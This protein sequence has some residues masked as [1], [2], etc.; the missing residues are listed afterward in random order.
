M[1]FYYLKIATRALLK[2]KAYTITMLL[3]LSIG[4]ASCILILLFVADELSFDQHHERKERIYRL[5][6]AVQGSDFEG[7]AK[8]NGPWGPAAQQEIPEIEAMTRFVICGELLFDNGNQKF[9]EPNGFY[10]DSSVFDI[11]SYDF[12]QGDPSTSLVGPKKIVITETFAKRYFGNEDAWGK[13]LRIDSDEDYIVTGILEDIPTTSHFTFDYLLSMPSLQN[14]LKHSWTEWNQFYTYFLLRQHTVTDDVENKIMVMLQKN[15][16]PELASNY[17][18]FLQALTDI[19]LRSHLHREMNANSD[20]L[21]IYIFSS[22]ALLILAISSVNFINTTTARATRRAKEIG[23]RKVNGAARRQLVIQF[24]TEVFV[25]C[26]A[27]LLIAQLLAVA[28]LP[29]LND[30]TA[31]NIDIGNLTQPIFV[32]GSVGITILTALLAGSYPA[33]YQSSLKPMQ[34]LKGRWSPSGKVS[35]QKVLVAFQFALSSILVIASVIIFRQLQFI[36]SKPLGFDP[37]QII[38]IPIQS[39]KLRDSYETVKHELLK[40]PGVLSVS[41]SGNIPGGSDWGI[42]TLPEGF[43]GDNSPS[44]RVM[45]VDQDFLKTYGMTVAYGRNFSKVVVTDTTAYLINEEAVKQLN[46]QDPLLK[47]F[48]MPAV[49]RPS[50][51]VVGV[52]KDFHFRSIHEEIGPLLFFIP[53]SKWYSIYSIKIDVRQSEETLKFVKREWE[54]FDPEHPFTFTFFDDQYTK[55][56]E[57]ERRLGTIVGYF[58]IIGIFLACMGLYSLASYTTEQRKKEIG[59]R[60]VIGASRI[61]VVA[62]LSKQYLVVLL[63]GFGVAL[64]IAWH[65]LNQWLNSFAYHVNFNLLLVITCGMMLMLI[66]LLTVGYRGLKAA[67]ANPV[68]SLKNE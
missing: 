5:A 9:Y 17:T 19:H 29:V 10:A 16:A 28:A 7:I 21:Y 35:L 6:T 44:I 30:L 57:Q 32:F 45:A 66:A 31:K 68:D 52:V 13:T 61:Q 18:P 62:L 12:I 38:T 63:V 8:V 40:H 24:L 11:F 25:I 27:S 47:T 51:N 26:F 2:Q 53:P 48:S 4:L 46:W 65:V 49:G 23:V 58:T 67:S 14:P 20:A 36:Q 54:R 50:G 55:L 43:N 59:I 41:I 1:I 3:A 56:Y 42:P 39:D 64:P 37:T 33:L 34:V 15:L 60:K 22:I